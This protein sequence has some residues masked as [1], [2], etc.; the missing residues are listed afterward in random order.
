RKQYR[1]VYNT[2]LQDRTVTT[3]TCCPGWTRPTDHSENNIKNI[4]GCTVRSHTNE[5]MNANSSKPK[6]NND[7]NGT[8]INNDTNSIQN[9][10]EPFEKRN[11]KAMQTNLQDYS[12]PYSQYKIPPKRM[13]GPN[14]KDKHKQ[15]DVTQGQRS[16]NDIH[17]NREVIRNSSE[18]KKERKSFRTSSSDNY[19]DKFNKLLKQQ[20]RQLRNHRRQLRL[21]VSRKHRTKET[22]SNKFRVNS[23]KSSPRKTIT[24]RG[25]S[26]AHRKISKEKKTRYDAYSVITILGDSDKGD[27]KTASYEKVRDGYNGD[28][29]GKQLG[30]DRT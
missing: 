28:S 6:F 1:T 14:Y 24:E 11:G 7:I 17:N 12:N 9:K 23:L 27:K 25:D 30:S 15:T 29:F 5:E 13:I 2:H 16:S 18:N 8:N 22:K 21:D 19:Q 20:K 26:R 4:E 3:L 10:K